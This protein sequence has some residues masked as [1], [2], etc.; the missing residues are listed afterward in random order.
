ML[1]REIL[2]ALALL[3]IGVNTLGAVPCPRATAPV[4]A[5]KPGLAA[6]TN[7][8]LLADDVFSAAYEGVLKILQSPNRCSEFFGGADAIDVFNQLVGKMEKNYLAANIGIRMSGKT[9]TIN[10]LQTNRTYRLF[11]KVSLN[12]NGPF[13]RSSNS[14]LLGA[15]KVGTYAPNTRE[16]RALMLLHELGHAVIA[17]D[18]DWLLPDD[19]NDANLSRNNSL[20]IEKECGETI[21]GLRRSH[22]RAAE[23]A[24]DVEENGE[25]KLKVEKGPVP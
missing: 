3:S 6:A 14:L 9:R 18:G 7:L 1:A 19:G 22:D 21:A 4:L 17:A 11:E 16:A 23:V 25:S 8:P 24:A 15:T 20:K 2:F 12:G 5:N 10:D 13:Y